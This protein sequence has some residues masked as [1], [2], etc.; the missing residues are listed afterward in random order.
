MW[1]YGRLSTACLASVFYFSL[2]SLV[3]SSSADDNNEGSWQGCETILAPSTMGWGVYAA[4]PF[5]K[6]EVVDIAPL[7]VTMKGGSNAIKNSA[8][9]DY[10]YGYIRNFDNYYAII[11][12]MDMFYNH[13]P[14]P[15]VDYLL[16]KVSGDTQAAGFVAKREIAAG[17]QLF[18]TYGST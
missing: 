14:E 10:V 1:P 5:Q 15:N 9:D 2:V 3:L 8:L 6:G 18:S 17:E 11:F 13:H 16:H 12:G 7:F 4:R